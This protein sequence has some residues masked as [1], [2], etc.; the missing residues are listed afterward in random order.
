M[1]VACQSKLNIERNLTGHD[2]AAHL[3]K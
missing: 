2:N 3:M 1:L